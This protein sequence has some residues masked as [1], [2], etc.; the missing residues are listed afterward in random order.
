MSLQSLITFCTIYDDVNAYPFL[1]I[2]MCSAG[3]A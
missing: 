2:E 1:F 3:P